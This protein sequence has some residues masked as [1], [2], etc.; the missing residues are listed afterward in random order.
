MANLIIFPATFLTVWMFRKSRVKKKRPSRIQEARERKSDTDSESVA[1]TS[2]SDLSNE[3]NKCEQNNPPPY[4]QNDMHGMNGVQNGINGIQNGRAESPP[5]SG[6]RKIGIPMEDPLIKQKKKVFSLPWYCRHLAWAFLFLNVVVGIT[7]SLFYGIQ[8]GE[9]KSRKWITSMM[10]AF[11]MSVFVTQP[12]KVCTS[13][14][15]NSLL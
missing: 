3:V 13:H 7:F 9:E 14:L 8:F 12:M 10:V 15:A 1:S 11:I 5:D 4:M 2:V 6:E